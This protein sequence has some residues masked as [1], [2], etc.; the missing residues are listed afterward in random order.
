VFQGAIQLNWR[1]SVDAGKSGMAQGRDGRRRGGIEKRGVT[2]SEEIGSVSAD[3][4]E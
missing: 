4:I 3:G 2:K 1:V